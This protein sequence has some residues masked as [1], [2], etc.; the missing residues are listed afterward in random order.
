MSE[1]KNEASEL[2]PLLSYD[3]FKVTA[4]FGHSEVKTFQR[5]EN[6]WLVFYGYRIDYDQNGV[7]TGRTKPTATGRLSIGENY[8]EPK[9]SFFYRIF[10]R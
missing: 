6:S 3:H 1:A 4:I 2:M 10:G 7:E 8:V 9:R 5:E